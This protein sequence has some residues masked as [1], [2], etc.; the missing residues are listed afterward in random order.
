[1]VAAPD[2]Q[3]LQVGAPKPGEWVTFKVITPDG[4]VLLSKEKWVGHESFKFTVPP[5]AVGK[6][7]KLAFRNDE[8]VAFAFSA[9]IPGWLA[10]HPNRLIVPESS[11]MP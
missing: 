5:A 8:D 11:E 4:K 10:S 9:H 1:M 7:W 6:V 3:P 2:V